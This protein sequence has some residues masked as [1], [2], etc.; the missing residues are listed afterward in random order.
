[1]GSMQ[2][3]LKTELFSVDHEEYIYYYKSVCER[4]DMRERQTDR[5]RQREREKGRKKTERKKMKERNMRE[6]EDKTREIEMG[7]KS[8]CVEN[9]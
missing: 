8:F 2:Y 1:M 6:R 5:Q 4:E 9:C 7:I 3:G